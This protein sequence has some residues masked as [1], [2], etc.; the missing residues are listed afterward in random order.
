MDVFL[1]TAVWIQMNASDEIEL[2]IILIKFSK[3]RQIAYGAFHFSFNISQAL[4]VAQ[5]ALSANCAPDLL[6][7]IDS[8][9]A[10]QPRVTLTSWTFLS[11][12]SF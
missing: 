6:L 5:H 1:P 3:L 9:Q 8:V 7:A 4:A 12:S 2:F 11:I 10:T